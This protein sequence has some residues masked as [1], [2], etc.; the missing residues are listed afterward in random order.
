MNKTSCRYKVHSNFHVFLGGSL[1]NQ[2]LPNNG[3]NTHTWEVIHFASN[4]NKYIP[5][6]PKEGLISYTEKV[7]RTHLTHTLYFIDKKLWFKVMKWLAEP[8]ISFW[9]DF[10]RC[11]LFYSV[12]HSSLKVLGQ[13][14]LGQIKYKRKTTLSS[15]IQW[16]KRKQHL[17]VSSQHSYHSVTSKSNFW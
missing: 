16:E 3:N 8:F 9:R 2:P 11:P 5:A 7:L 17:Q 10:L 4:S 15:T 14:M 13:K 6:P 1:R 12:V